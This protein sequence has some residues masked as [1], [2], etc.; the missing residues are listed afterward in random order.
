MVLSSWKKLSVNS[1]QVMKKRLR[2]LWRSSSLSGQPLKVTW[3]RLTQASIR[4]G[5]E[6]PVI[7]VKGKEKALSGQT[8]KPWLQTYQL[9]IPVLPIMPFDAM[10]I[11]LREGIEALPH[12]YVLVTTLKAAKMRKGLKWVYGGAIAGVLASALIAVILQVVFP[13]VTSGANHWNYW[14]WRW[15][16][17][18]CDDDSDWNLAPQQV[19]SQTVGMTL[20]I[21]RWRRWRLLEVLYPCLPSVSWLFSVKVPRPSFSMLV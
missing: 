6:T 11:L 2:Q 17:C 4:A 13:A 15:Y 14:R 12:C 16:L 5:E 3:A 7:M 19:F 10:L 1:N 21:A 9:S 20:W 8:C 18:S